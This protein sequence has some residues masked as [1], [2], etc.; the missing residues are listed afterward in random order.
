MEPMNRT[1][2]ALLA[3]FAAS[4]LALVAAGCGDADATPAKPVGTPPMASLQG[5]A[6]EAAAAKKLPEQKPTESHGLH[7]V[8]KLS[9]NIVSGSE[10]HDE[11]ALKEIAAMGVKTVISVD[12]KEPDVETAKKYGLRYVH[13][14]IQYSGL[15][16]DETRRIA[17]SFLDLPGPFFVHC[18]HG[19]HRGPAAA[20]VGRVVLDGA[21]REQAIA[22]M[23]QY[24]GTSEKYEGLYQAIATSEMPTDAELKKMKYDFPSRAPIKGFR[25]AMVD[26]S[27]PWDDVELLQKR[28]W[29]ADPEHPD[30]DALNSAKRLAQVFE[31]SA[32]LPE[33]TGK[34][35]DFRG[36]LDDSVKAS[37][38]LVDALEKWKAGDAAAGKAAD[39]AYKTLKQRCDACHKPYR[40]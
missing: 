16:E 33:I 6:Y 12:G 1:R 4:A 37:K 15:S 36:W 32:A 18:F 38:E 28:G 35:K 10:P 19:K 31:A 9:P 24:C 27:R 14:P 25:H 22:E 29:A 11:A 2:P 21:T 8:F 30:V 34:P 23:R 17:K 20:A 5:K 39:A 40:N 3:P 7:N 26:V 13:I